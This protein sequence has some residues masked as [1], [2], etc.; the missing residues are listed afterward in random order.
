MELIILSE[1]FFPQPKIHVGI[2]TQVFLDWIGPDCLSGGRFQ[3]QTKPK[4]VSLPSILIWNTFFFVRICYTL[5]LKI[6]LSVLP[7]SRGEKRPS[8]PICSFAGPF[9]RYYRLRHGEVV[10]KEE[11][12]GCLLCFCHSAAAASTLLFAWPCG[13]GSGMGTKCLPLP[14]LLIELLPLVSID[15]QQATICHWDN[16]FSTYSSS[17]VLNNMIQINQMEF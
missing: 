9:W 17:L 8:F 12:D 2:A 14:Q 16:D 6:S 7:K 10:Q 13:L 4:Q 3:N 5:F 11:R 1:S 15:L